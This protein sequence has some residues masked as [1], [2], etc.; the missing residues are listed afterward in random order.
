MGSETIRRMPFAELVTTSDVAAHL[1]RPL[2]DGAQTDP[3]GRPSGRPIP[4][5][6]ISMISA[7]SGNQPIPD[8]DV[9]SHV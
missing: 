1:G 7:S 3:A 8:S 9:L 6:V 5:S 4:S 2:T